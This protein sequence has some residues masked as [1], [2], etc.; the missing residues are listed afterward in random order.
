MREHRWETFSS[1]T[2][3]EVIQ[4]TQ[5]LRAAGL[6]PADPEKDVISY[7]EEWTVDNL[8]GIRILDPW[9]LEDITLIHVLENWNDDFFLLA[10]QYHTLVQQY[11]SVNTYCS[12]CHPWTIEERMVT[13]LQDAMFWIGFRHAHAFIRTR[14]HTTEI[15]APSETWADHQRPMWLAER[16]AAFRSVVNIL[17]IPIDIISNDQYITLQTPRS[18]T[19]FFCSWPDA[20]GP[21][22]F[23]LN[24]P[25]VFEFLV[26][27]S[28]LAATY[29][30]RP[31]SVR[32]YLTGFTEDQLVEFDSLETTKRLVYRCSVHSVLN[33]LPELLTCL[34]QHGRLYSTLCEF[35][36]S[37]IL[38]MGQDAAAIIGVV[39][40]QNTFH[41]EVR[42]NQCPVNHEETTQ[43]LESLL[44]TPV[45]YAP[46][47]AFP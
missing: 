11:Q 36:T 24:S 5:R 29:A 8:Q 33:E 28:Q 20:F 14:L 4:M 16:Q 1:Y 41:I 32:A 38:P 17:D 31:K 23:E 22:Q 10:G 40:S 19:P 42:L 15:V 39:G 43:W 26:P 34:D 44:G 25:D 7:I 47:S 13:L 21:C 35:Q 12:L 9:P 37:S 30:D 45:R 18:D 46:L 2:F 3:D 6:T 27:A